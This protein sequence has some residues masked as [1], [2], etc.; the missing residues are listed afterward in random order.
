MSTR[1]VLLGLALA[2]HA[3]M[4]APASAT[5]DIQKREVLAY[6][7]IVGFNETVPAT[8]EG[9][10]MIK[11]KPLLKV[12]GGCV[13]FPAVDA[14]GN[15]GYASLEIGR[16]ACSCTQLDILTAYSGGLDITGSPSG[17]CSTSTGQVYA[18]AATHE[19]YFAIMYSW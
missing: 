13:P 18:R 8:A 10:L 2:A 14:A 11:Y 16:H 4:A 1:S 12:I 3:V 6:D 19:N 17:S 5:A 9:A 15:V 7:A